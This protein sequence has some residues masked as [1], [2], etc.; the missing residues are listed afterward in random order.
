MTYEQIRILAIK[1]N[2]SL[3]ELARTV[4]ESPQNFIKKLQ[5]DTLSPTDLK[6]IA[7]KLGISYESYFILKDGEKI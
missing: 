5:R 2:I 3:S 1:L 7:E 6:V 4:G